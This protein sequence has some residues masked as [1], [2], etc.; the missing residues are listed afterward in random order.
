MRAAGRAESFAV[1]AE[2]ERLP[3]TESVPEWTRAG[4]RSLSQFQQTATAASVRRPD[5]QPVV[6]I[7]LNEPM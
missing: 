5:A 4:P 1:N 6:T 3:E 2:R 7:T